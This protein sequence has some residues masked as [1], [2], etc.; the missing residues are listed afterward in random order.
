M[1]HNQ[2]NVILFIK[3]EGVIMN[4]NFKKYKVLV[5]D[6]DGTLLNNNHEITSLTLKFF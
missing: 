5:F 2:F 3:K 4:A 6:L 1:G